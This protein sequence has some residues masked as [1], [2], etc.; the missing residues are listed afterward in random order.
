MENG[1]NDQHKR[2][3]RVGSSS[4]ARAISAKSHCQLPIEVQ[5]SGCALPMD[6]CQHLV[7]HI[8]EP[9]FRPAML[10]KGK[11]CFIFP[12]RSWGSIDDR[13]SK[14]TKVR[15]PDDCVIDE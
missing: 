13:L 12:L 8:H 10:K 11:K 6:A 2:V 5:P 15:V 7:L 4:D 1:G 9:Y 3:I 14:Y